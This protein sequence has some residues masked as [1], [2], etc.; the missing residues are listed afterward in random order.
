MGYF[1]PSYP[2]NPKNHISFLFFKKKPLE[3]SSFYTSVPKVMTI[4]YTVPKIWCMMDV[5]FIF[6]FGLFFALLPQHPEIWCTKDGRTDA[7]SD[8][9]RWVSHLK[10]IY[11]T[12]FILSFNIKNTS[13]FVYGG[14]WSKTGLPKHKRND[15][16]ITKKRLSEIYYRR[17]GTMEI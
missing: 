12:S 4:C 5:I 3:I 8:I 15:L 10:T 13:S 14:N 2:T 16:W 9:K 7:K 6:H 11:S 17:I 1:L